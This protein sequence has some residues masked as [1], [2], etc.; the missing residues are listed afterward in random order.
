MRLDVLFGIIHLSFTEHSFYTIVQRYMIRWSLLG[1]INK[2][3]SRLM[4]DEL[5]NLEETTVHKTY[6]TVE[7]IT[8]TKGNLK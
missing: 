8:E 3:K 2:T 5:S 4:R 7:D 6:S 1:V